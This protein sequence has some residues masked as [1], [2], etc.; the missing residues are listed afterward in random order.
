MLRTKLLIL[1]VALAAIV[2]TQT[3]QAYPPAGVDVIS[4]SARVDIYDVDSTVLIE[5][6]ILTGHAVVLR[7]NP[8]DPGDG[9]WRIDTQLDTLLLE[10]YSISQGDTMFV[11]LNRTMPPATGYIQQITPGIDYP[12]ES[13]FDVYYLVTFGLPAPNPPKSLGSVRG[14]FEIDQATGTGKAN[15]PALTKGTEAT[16]L[17]GPIQKVW[18]G[19]PGEEKDPADFCDVQW[20]GEPYYYW[21]NTVFGPECWAAYQDPVETGCPTPVYPFGVTEIT[22]VVYAH[23]DV[24]ID[25][26]PVIYD[27]SDPDVIGP[28]LCEGPIHN[29]TLPAGGWILGLPFED[30]CCVYGPYYAGVIMHTDLGPDVLSIVTDDGVGVPPRSDATYWNPYCQEG[31]LDLVDDAG[32]DANLVLFSGGYN[33]DQNDCPSAEQVVWL[34]YDEVHMADTIWRIPPNGRQYKDPR[35]IAVYDQATGTLVG[36]VWHKHVVDPP[37]PGADT[38]PTTGTMPVVIGPVP[39]I[40]GQK[41]DEIVQLWGSSVVSWGPPEPGGAVET[42]LQEMYLEGFSE[43]WGPAYLY[44]PQ[45]APGAAVS[46]GEEFFPAES[47]FDVYY[48]VEFPGAGY[49]VVPAG[50]SPHM[51]ADVETFPP[52]NRKYNPDPEWHPVIDINTPVPDTIGWVAPIHWVR[53]QTG[54]CCDTATGAC[55]ETTPQDCNL[56]TEI[57]MGIGI[58][59][60]PNPCPQPETII[61][62][63]PTTGLMFVWETPDPPGP[64]QP[65]DDAIYVEGE[66]V[67]AWGPPGGGVIA[68]EI[69][70][71]DLTGT[72]YLYGEAH[73]TLPYPAPGQVYEPL[74]GESFFDVYYEVELPDMG[75]IIAPAD[76]PPHMVT[77]IDDIPPIPS[78]YLPD[79]AVHAIR[80]I[81]TGGIIGWVRPIHFVGRTCCNTDGITGDANY[82]GAVN[83]ADLSFLVTFLF[84]A[85]PPPP[86]PPEADV[87]CGGS[88]NVADLTYIVDYLFFQ[89]APPC[90]CPPLIR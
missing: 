36:Y 54:A 21:N 57:F 38:I 65:Y 56:P 33:A 90:P 24:T 47:F 8:Y 74:P 7:G 50:E 32:I 87:D 12:A 41:P 39:P 18:P 3:V 55:R 42:E 5:T 15:V 73:L 29:F 86:C 34:N 13:F 58:P 11:S 9:R 35:K 53:P 19:E 43:L 4:T 63:I 69:V 28:L 37:G 66:A 71:M 48:E 2:C 1:A 40:P 68:T 89:G 6:V 44:L 14:D 31:W 22:W 85:G 88:I 51:V 45:P 61:D 84:G 10:G 26:Q 60:I 81:A 49:R 72:S 59:C 27:Y 30:T 46:T 52:Y 76:A 17:E 83:V 79:P 77:V 67:V 78:K 20:Q 16:K 75:I 62:T 25:V 70:S 64:G 80:D 82:D 23:Q